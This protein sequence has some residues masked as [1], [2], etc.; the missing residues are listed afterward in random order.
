[1]KL[2]NNQN[3]RRVLA[4]ISV[5]T[6]LIAL[7]GCNLQA[8]RGAQDNAQNDT[9]GNRLSAPGGLF[10]GGN[11]G[12]APNGDAP[13][14]IA[15]DGE[16]PGGTAQDGNNQG[17]FGGNQGN[18]QGGL[19]DILSGLNPGTGNVAN[20][21]AIPLG[22]YSSAGDS[23]GC[24]LTLSN[25]NT[26]TLSYVDDAGNPV[27][28]TGPATITDDQITINDTK[29]GQQVTCNY[30]VDGNNC[31]LNINGSSYTCQKR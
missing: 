26:C 13:N 27:T 18:R 17:N 14:N 22:L 24:S 25:N 6:L 31:T 30:T 4:L 5:F 7:A 21:N 29:T 15:D 1:M 8:N 19:N 23:K 9:Q 2:K 12:N 3:I 28:C 10:Q 16:V 20:Q 11:L